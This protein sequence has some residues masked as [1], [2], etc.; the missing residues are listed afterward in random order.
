MI[1]IHSFTTRINYMFYRNVY[2]MHQK[3]IGQEVQ[4]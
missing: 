2:D 3:N 4:Y 1:K